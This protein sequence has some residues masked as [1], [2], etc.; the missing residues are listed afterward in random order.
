MLSNTR[1]GITLKLTACGKA[2]IGDKEIARAGDYGIGANVITSNNW[3][4]INKTGIYTNSSSEQPEL[5]VRAGYLCLI[6]MQTSINATQVCF[7]ANALLPLT[8]RRSFD[9]GSWGSGK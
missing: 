7:R 6:H 8:Y 4:L 3:D 1:S 5:P 9:N 2:L